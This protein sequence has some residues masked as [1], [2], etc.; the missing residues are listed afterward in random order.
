M[1]YIS[2]DP[3]LLGAF[4]K[5]EDP[6]LAVARLLYNNKSLEKSSPERNAAKVIVLALF[7]G[8]G[9]V[10]LAYRLGVTVATAREQLAAFKRQFRKVYSAVDSI[11]R[12]AE[13]RHYSETVLG[14]RRYGD[15]SMPGFK[16]KMVNFPIQSTSAEM[17]KK[18][19][20]RL[21]PLLSGR[22]AFIVD[23]VHDEV[24]VECTYDIRFDVA[25]VV[26]KAMVQAA[27]DLVDVPFKADVS[28]GRYWGDNSLGEGVQ[29]E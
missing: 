28:I 13:A 25:K 14:R 19:V 26:G 11:V 6:Y 23:L 17:L 12:E 4:E 29:S 2:Q 3:V 8:M 20:V 24:V 18:A 15:P 27:N 5:G 10:T 7:Y 1:A 21:S 22:D 9:V 16:G